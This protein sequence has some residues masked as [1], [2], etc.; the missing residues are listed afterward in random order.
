MSDIESCIWLL[1]VS[2]VRSIVPSTPG[3]IPPNALRKQAIYAASPRAI[4]Y[5]GR[6]ARI[7]CSIFAT[8]KWLGFWQILAD[9]VGIVDRLVVQVRS[10]DAVPNLSDDVLISDS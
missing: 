9:W 3:S 7:I 2:G 8:A 10:N 5:S 4:D 6:S 1:H